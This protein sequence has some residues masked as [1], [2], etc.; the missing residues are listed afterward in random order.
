MIG[1]E[2]AGG[3]QCAAPLSAFDQSHAQLTLDST[4]VLGNRRLTDAQFPPGARERASTREG[5]VG[6]QACF[7]L[8]NRKLY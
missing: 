8:H 7:Q 1:E 6:A 5:R 2:L 4:D 3:G